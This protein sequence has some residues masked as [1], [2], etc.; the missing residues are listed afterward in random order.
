MLFFSLLTYF[1]FRLT[2]LC[3][4]FSDFT[5]S[6]KMPMLLL[7]DIVFY[8]HLFFSNY[9][10]TDLC[11]VLYDVIALYISTDYRGFINT[12]WYAFTE[13]SFSKLW[14]IFIILLINFAVIISPS[15]FWIFPFSFFVMYYLLSMISLSGVFNLYIWLRPS[16]DISFALIF[17]YVAKTIYL[18]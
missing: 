3:N 13:I 14:L 10:F 16:Q 17:W 9:P 4:I 18:S 11:F 7:Y 1:G 15:L 5:G 2:A 6:D 12:L 8:L